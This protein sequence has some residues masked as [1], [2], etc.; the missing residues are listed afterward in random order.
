MEVSSTIIVLSLSI[1]SLGLFLAAGIYWFPIWHREKSGM[2]HGLFLTNAI[3]AI[4]TA[5]KIVQIICFI[6]DKNDSSSPF[7]LSVGFFVS[8]AAVVQFALS[9]GYFNWKE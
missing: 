5:L 3:L 9:R 2:A 1:L 8:F 7:R 6:I 4:A